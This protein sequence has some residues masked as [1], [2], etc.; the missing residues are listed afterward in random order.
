[1]RSRL[2]LVAAVAAGLAGCAT[3][4]TSAPAG[5]EA[6][7]SAAATARP[8][9]ASGSAA[10]GT[11]S[12]A[13]TTGGTTSPS[14]SAGS[15]GA[16]CGA[17]PA[18]ALASGELTGVEFVSPSRGWAVGQGAILVTADGGAHWA[19]QLT[20][21]LDLTAVDFVNAS[22]GW[23]TGTGSLLATTDGGAHWTRLAELCPLIR[24]VHFTSA[25]DGYAVAGG[26][27]AAAGGSDTEIPDLG[28]VVLVTRDGG[29]T[30]AKAAAPANAQ[31]VCF[32]GEKNGWL[33]ANGQLYRTGDGGKSW[34]ALTS[35]PSTSEAGYA[36]EMSVQCAGTDTAWAVRAG[37]GAG[38]SQQPHVAFHADA[39]GV[40]AV[41]AEQYYHL[42][43]DPAR[44]SPGAYAGPFSALSPSSAVFIDSCAPCGAGT[45]PWAVASGSGASLAERGNVGGVN[46]ADAAAF[47]S[48]RAGWVTGTYREYPAKGNSRYQQRVLATSDGGKTWQVQWASPWH[49]GTAQ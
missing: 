33:G 29:H 22:A 9:T 5:G 47:L 17:P 30:W 43:G 24:S 11:T 48:P 42:Q 14:S 7:S 46:V 3:A 38:M 23:A 8:A 32:N 26:S 27:V 13:A 16:G 39:S 31:T 49:Y 25:T 21:R 34:T 12:P 40:T 36:A 41:Y 20:G 37:P 35:P 6:S 44:N 1:M 15:S 10:G 18:P 28:G 4:S 19:A 2:L 45:A